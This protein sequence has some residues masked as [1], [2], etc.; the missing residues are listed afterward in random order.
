MMGMDRVERMM[1]VVVFWRL[2][3]LVGGF[4]DFLLLVVIMVVDWWSK[5]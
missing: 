5:L 4:L 1:K 3:L 2:V